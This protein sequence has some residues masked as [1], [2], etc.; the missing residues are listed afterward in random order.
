MRGVFLMALWLLSAGP[1]LAQTGPDSLWVQPFGA[2]GECD[3]AAIRQTSDGGYLLAGTEI[4]PSGD[5]VRA[6]RLDSSGHLLWT[7]DYC[8]LWAF[9][10]RD[11]REAAD[12]DFLIA[13]T[14][15]SQAADSQRSF[16]I[17][18]NSQGDTLWVKVFGD[19]VSG[20]NAAQ[21][22]KDGG[23]VLAG[24][25]IG[26]D[27]DGSD[28]TFIKMDMWG[29]LLWRHRFGEPGDE[30]AFA[31]SGC[32]D[33]GWMIAGLGKS[34]EGAG[35]LHILRT[36]SS[37]SL[38][39]S[40]SYPLPGLQRIYGMERSGDGY[41][42]GGLRN[43]AGDPCNYFLMKMDSAGIPLWVGYCPSFCHPSEPMMLKPTLSGFIM[44]RYDVSLSEGSRQMELYLFDEAGEFRYHTLFD[45]LGYR[46]WER[47]YWYY[48]LRVASSFADGIYD[49]FV[50]PHLPVDEKITIDPPAPKPEKSERHG[51]LDSF[52]NVYWASF[53]L[54]HRQQVTVTV[55]DTTGYLIRTIADDVYS[56][57]SHCEIFDGWSLPPSIYF[58]RVETEEMQ[59][60]R[61]VV[62]VR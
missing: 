24:W 30:W 54:N 60:V 61:K 26:R 7:R 37:G 23:C 51:P 29:N 11:A 9:K 58:L 39:W 10:V 62:L 34:T 44:A 31:L 45:G 41:I 6:V 3:A 40:K 12:G 18:T 49:Y 15:S 4:S 38:R 47:P 21:P 16:V 28:I 8:S 2:V 35:R 53:I 25:E 13:G 5:E 59:E 57:G 55:Y 27:L 50:D 43:P 17:R 19:T 36:D 14:T 22:T 1:L 56:S 46:R 32:S 20:I 33:G 42:T 52:G 48:E